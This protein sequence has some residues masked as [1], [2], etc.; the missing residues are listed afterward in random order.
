MELSLCYSSAAL[1]SGKHEID[2]PSLHKSK[3][4]GSLLPFDPEIE[5]IYR[6]NKKE[7]R[8][9]NQSS[10]VQLSDEQSPPMLTTLEISHLRGGLNT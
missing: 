6:R 7:T 3:S 10:R 1:H 4:T 9:R 5:K 8:Q 2:E